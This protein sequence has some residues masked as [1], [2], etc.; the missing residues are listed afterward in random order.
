MKPKD[1][2][3]HQ[4]KCVQGKNNARNL[5]YN[6]Q[7]EEWKQKNQWRLATEFMLATNIKLD[8]EKHLVYVNQI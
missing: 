7:E 1:Q 4:K 2:C 5:L 6:N 8:K 3:L